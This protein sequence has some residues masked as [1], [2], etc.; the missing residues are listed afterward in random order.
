MSYVSTLGLYA[1]HWHIY[2]QAVVHDGRTRRS[3]PFVINEE[4]FAVGIYN[5]CEKLHFVGHSS[6]FLE[7]SVLH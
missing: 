1:S 3:M 5:F 7:G 6:V 4:T 2:W